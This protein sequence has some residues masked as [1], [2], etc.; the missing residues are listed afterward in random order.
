MSW[1]DIINTQYSKLRMVLPSL[2]RQNT[3]NDNDIKFL[4]HKLCLLSSDSSSSNSNSCNQSNRMTDH[5]HPATPLVN[6][7]SN[8]DNNNVD[9]HAQQLVRLT[10]FYKELIVEYGKENQ[11]KSMKVC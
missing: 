2:L 9:E 7:P 4:C 3:N 1:Y 8:N 6:N 10:K 5:F 11:C